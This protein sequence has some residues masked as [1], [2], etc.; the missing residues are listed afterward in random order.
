MFAYCEECGY[1][2]GD[3]STMEE[4]KEKVIR[5]GGKIEPESVCPKC[6]AIG[7]LHID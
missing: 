2:S 3:V 6:K 5:D 1:D 4:L 7:S